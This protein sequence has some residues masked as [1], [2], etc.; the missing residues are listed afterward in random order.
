MAWT[1]VWCKCDP[2]IR[3][4]EMVAVAAGD[5]V[6]LERYVRSTKFFE[7]IGQSYDIARVLGRFDVGSGGPG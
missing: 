5:F 6:L 1:C 2:V 4:L 3:D 7:R